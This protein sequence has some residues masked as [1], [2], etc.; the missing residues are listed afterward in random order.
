MSRR[1]GGRGPSLGPRLPFSLTKEIFPDSTPGHRPAGDSGRFRASPRGRGSSTARGGRYGERGRGGHAQRSGRRGAESGHRGGRSAGPGRVTATGSEQEASRGGLGR[2]RRGRSR[3]GGDPQLRGEKRGR[4]ESAVRNPKQKRSTTKFTEL[5]GPE[6]SQVLTGSDGSV[7]GLAAEQAL[8][9]ELARKLG[10]KKGRGLK[11]VGDGLDDLVLGGAKVAPPKASSPSGAMERGVKPGRPSRAAAT[12]ASCASPAGSNDSGSVSDYASDGEDAASD[13]GSDASG[14]EDGHLSDGLADSDG[15]S[16]SEEDSLLNGLADSG[17]SGSEEADSVLA[18]MSD[19]EEEGSDPEGSDL[20]GAGDS[21]AANGGTSS[22]EAVGASGSEDGE[23]TE[24]SAGKPQEPAA[25]RPAPARPS[26]PAA[27]GR[28]LPPAARAAAAGSDPTIQDSRVARAVRGQ[29]NRLAESNLQGIV[30]ELAR[31]HRDEARRAVTDAVVHEL[32]A[33]AAEGPRASEAFAAVAAAAVAGLAASVRSAG[34]IAAFLSA[35]GAR[36][37][38]SLRDD[39]DAL[40]ARNLALVVAQLHALGALRADLVMSLLDAWRRRF[41]EAD[42]AATSH[43]LGAAGLSLRAADPQAMR[44]YIVAV[45]EA[46]ADARAR[47]ALSAR[48]QALLDLVMDTKNNRKRDGGRHAVLSPTT[49]KWLRGLGVEEVAVGGIPWSKVLSPVK[50]GFW[51]QPS[52]ADAA[53]AGRLPSLRGAS[54]AAAEALE[55]TPGAGG[56]TPAQLLRLAARHGMNTEVRRTVFCLVMGSEDYVDAFE[57]LVRLGLKGTQEQEIVRV[58]VLCCLQE[59]AYNPYY[60]LLLGRLGATSRAHQTT[61]RYACWDALGE[62]GP[63]MDLRRLT[64]LARLCADA[65]AQGAMSPAFLKKGDW[66]GAQSARHVVLWRLFFEHLL[67]RCDDPAALFKPWR[68]RP[69]LQELRR[70]LRHY[71][72]HSLG[73]W[74]AKQEPGQRGRSASD[75]ETLLHRVHAVE[76]ALGG[77]SAD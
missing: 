37:E 77:G 66:R 69:A 52:A 33:A 73:P 30:G 71:L 31:M 44:D 53:A 10:M 35:L 13:L 21:S 54:L 12:P 67:L 72:R 11:E 43:L 76:R 40:A 51:W 7:A 32:T 24:R 34:V 50:V 45:T 65:V 9:A 14:S 23:D 48:G 28:Y 38:A 3:G 19:S 27:V 70:G 46:A 25:T 39:G 63:D 8:Q 62:V 4:D 2:G 47:G 36:L 60:A 58:I 74:A 1:G 41:G 26:P 56:Q 57:K 15:A 59:G 61:L 16:G 20:S 18:G 75:L 5:L 22:D 49:L 68:E 55:D 64:N 42:V 29:L 6:G 17:A